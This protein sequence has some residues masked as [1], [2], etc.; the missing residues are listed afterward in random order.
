MNPKNLMTTIIFVVM[1]V[2]AASILKSNKIEIA[3]KT[4]IISLAEKAATA[5]ILKSELAIADE[6]ST[7]TSESETASTP[8]STSNTESNTQQAPVVSDPIVYD[9]LTMSQLSDKLNRSLG[10]TLS[11]TGSIFAN[12]AVQLGID[13][14]LAVAISLHET[15]CKW[16][17]SGLVTSCNN[18][19]GMIGNCYSSLEEGIDAYMDNLANN[20]I[21]QGLNTPELMARKYTGN[22]GTSW[23]TAVNK[24]IQS[25]KN[26]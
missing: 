3:S 19:G 23:I 2:A 17:C 26:N 12:K 16:N 20:Y 10:S 8:T 18:V 14:Y 4:N 1:F 5:P 7:S 6:E 21:Y 15:G 13:P 11:G 25:I 24:Y 9:G 22:T